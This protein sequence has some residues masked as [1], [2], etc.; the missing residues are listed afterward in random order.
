MTNAP[1]GQQKITLSDE[2]FDKL[3]TF[4]HIKTGV[5]LSASKKALIVCR[6]R[7]RLAALNLGTFTDYFE[8]LSKPNSKELEHFIN[9][10]TTNET[11][12]FRHTKQFNFL[13]KTILPKLYNDHTYVKIWSCAS[14]TGEEPYS[15]SIACHIFSAK[16][17]NFRYKILAT[18]I[19]S[20]VIKVAEKALYNENSLRK[21]PGTLR[22]EYF[23]KK[24][25]GVGGRKKNN[26]Q[27]KAFIQKPVKFKLHNLLDQFDGDRFHI[28][29]LRN[30]MI[31]FDERTRKKVVSSLMDCL[32]SQ[33][34]IIVSLS[35][36]LNFLPI[37]LK[38]VS[39]GVYQ[40]I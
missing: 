36:T 1:L 34:Y 17:K 19:N 16:V 10:V 9:E 26:Y 23:Q 29:F 18:D 40:K 5:F 31:Y 24:V 14:S 6:L 13:Y 15:L 21:V 28:I 27:L 22:R 32:K 4:L 37:H 2:E 25:I 20:S 30:V 39:S 8:Y 35:E 7:K 33:G 11:C 12:F 3:K 38:Q